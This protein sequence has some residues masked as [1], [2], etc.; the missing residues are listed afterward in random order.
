M[1]SS[2]TDLMPV[3]DLAAG[4]D[5]GST[6]L[7]HHQQYP[8]PPPSSSSTSGA[9][10]HSSGAAAAIAGNTLC[11]QPDIK[12]FNLKFYTDHISLQCVMNAK[13]SQLGGHTYAR[14]PGGRG[15]SKM[16]A[17]KA[18]KLRAYLMYGP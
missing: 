16:R 17:K 1:V 7:Q 13:V 14:K 2:G 5:P 15:V 18:E 9:G 11:S 12:Q 4:K 8:P 10:E 6:R 3:R